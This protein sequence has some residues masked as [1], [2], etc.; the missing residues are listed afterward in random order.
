M[1]GCIVL[2]DTHNLRILYLHVHLMIFLNEVHNR[3]ICFMVSSSFKIHFEI[4]QKPQQVIYTHLWVMLV[5]F[6]C[7]V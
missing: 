2:S 4:V 3:Q 5:I 1:H 6:L 7:V